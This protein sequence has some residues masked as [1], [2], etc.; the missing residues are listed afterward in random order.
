[1]NRAVKY[2]LTGG[3]AAAI[4]FAIFA[5]LTRWA[6]WWWF[7]AGCV[8]FVVATIVNYIISIRHVFESG[9]RFR[10]EQEIALVFLISAVGLALNQ[11]VLFFLIRGGIAILLAKLG[12]TGAAL[13]WNY[14]ARRG[15][16][17]KDVSL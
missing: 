6:G 5:A 9:V 2:V 16:V 8:S 11:T 17:F 7:E 13:F 10:K 1:M 3:I 4:D 12:A 14:A 15:F